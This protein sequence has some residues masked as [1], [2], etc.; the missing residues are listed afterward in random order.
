[1]L[2]SIEHVTRMLFPLPVGSLF[3]YKCKNKG[4]NQF[5][6]LIKRGQTI[7]GTILGGVKHY[8]L[9]CNVQHRLYKRGFEPWI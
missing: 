5:T 2:Y 6:G 9:N 8:I 4:V 7:S 3:K 1:M